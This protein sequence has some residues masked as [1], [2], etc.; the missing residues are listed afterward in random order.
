V[1]QNSEIA[2]ATTGTVGI[3]L[4]LGGGSAIATVAPYL[5]I[6]PTALGA[7]FTI[8]YLIK[9]QGRSTGSGAVG[10]FSQGFFLLPD[11]LNGAF[12]TIAG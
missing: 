6:V 12:H 2:I 1:T 3:P 5:L 11:W 8:G 7:G 10:A 9:N 4:T